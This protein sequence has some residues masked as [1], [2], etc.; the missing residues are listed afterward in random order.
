MRR[1]GRGGRSEESYRNEWKA[2]RR[3]LKADRKD[4]PEEGGGPKAARG[5]GADT[6]SAPKEEIS[7]ASVV[8]F[9]VEHT[10]PQIFAALGPAVQV[11][12][13]H[14]VDCSWAG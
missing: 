3:I 10:K 2:L 13:L 8:H 12:H 7:M 4:W 14:V 5:K 1:S 9:L 6:S 11:P